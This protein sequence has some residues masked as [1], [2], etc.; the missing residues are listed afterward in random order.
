MMSDKQQD[1]FR[2][3]GKL[4]VTGLI[5]GGAFVAPDVALAGDPSTDDDFASI[6]E[7]L[8]EWS[9]GS[10]GRVVAIAF[11]L[12]GLI[13]GIGSQSV[14]AFAVGVGAGVGLYNAETIVNSLFG[15]SVPVLEA[16]RGAL[17]AG[18][19]TIGTAL[20]L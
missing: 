5:V 4:A 7:T 9:Q 14:I 3:T 15:A 16:S 8:V 6:W 17:E 12:V 20:G 18:G 19:T 11:I 2:I 10:M 13:R 1:W